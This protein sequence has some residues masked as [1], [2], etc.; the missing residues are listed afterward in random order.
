MV[1]EKP[2]PV[3]FHPTQ[4]PRRLTWAGVRTSE[5]TNRPSS[6]IGTLLHLRLF[7][8]LRFQFQTKVVCTDI[9]YLEPVLKAQFCSILC[10]EVRLKISPEIWKGQISSFPNFSAFR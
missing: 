8:V 4:T 10:D 7:L 3:P 1:C 2:V 9:E 5:A 6:S